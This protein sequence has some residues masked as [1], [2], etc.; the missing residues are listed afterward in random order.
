MARRPSK[1]AKSEAAAKLAE[2]LN[3]VAYA[4]KDKGEVPYMAHA[5][6]AGKTITATDGTFSAGHAIEEEFAL[7]PHIGRLIDAL[8]RAGTSLA[9]TENENGTLL[10]KG[11]KIRATVPCIAGDQMPQIMPDPCIATIDDRIKE[12][13]AKLLPLIRE[14][15]E[16][17]VE[18]SILLRANTMLSCNGT[19]I[20]EYWHGID[21]PPG[22]AI[23]KT[24]AAAVAAS[25]KPLAGFGFTPKSVTFYFEDGS[26]YKTQ[27][28]GE[29]WPN[30]D[31]L[32]D[33]PSY[34]AP[35]PVGLFEAVRAIESFS[36]DGAVHFHDEKLKTTYD[37]YRERSGA[38]YGATYDVPGLQ[39]GHTFT[40]KLL[41]LIEPVCISVDY[42]SNDDRAFF[43]D[44]GN[45]RGSI[46]KRQAATTEPAPTP[47]AKWGEVETPEEVEIAASWT[48]PDDAS[49]VEVAEAFATVQAGGWG[50]PE[51]PSAPAAD[52]WAA[53]VNPLGIEDDDIPF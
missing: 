39:A 4:T 16:R 9:L 20:F 24:F 45:L 33:Y 17:V 25:T 14:D 49:G 27:L 40:A 34:P 36:K 23:P 10:V 41:R 1:K 2:A 18:V 43:F 15:A 28:F 35:V 48:L 22:L 37:N 5:R 26:W 3:F 8:N 6:V 47:S 50:V 44:G 52:P 21:L 31:Q 32:F 30:V 7:C 53:I 12:G 42:T 51:A 19:V 38:L 29:E 11:D 13:F 46:M